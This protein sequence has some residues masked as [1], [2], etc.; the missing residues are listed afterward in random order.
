MIRARCPFSN[1]TRFSQLSVN[2][3]SGQNRA[4]I[5]KWS[6]Q[7]E[8]CSLHPEV[9]RPES[10]AFES[11]GRRLAFAALHVRA[12]RRWMGRRHVRKRRLH[13]GACLSGCSGLL[14]DRTV[15]SSVEEHVL[16]RIQTH[17]EPS[18]GLDR[19][20]RHARRPRPE[21]CACRIAR[22]R[23]RRAFLAVGMRNSGCFRA[24][25]PDKGRII[26]G[27][28]ARMDPALPSLSLR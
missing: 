4:R 23:V 10:S 16:R 26:C 18:A 9:Q 21:L 1:A 14:D 13:C 12:C 5:S 2:N 24:G 20:L 3:L 6:R 7:V 15:A 28:P 19:G 22:H 17:A 25:S 27:P 11:V 8:I